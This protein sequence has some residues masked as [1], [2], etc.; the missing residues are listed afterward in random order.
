M[1]HG[2]YGILN[3]FITNA[4]LGKPI[5]VYGDG[6]QT[7]D[8]VFVNDVVDGFIRSAITPATDGEIYFIGSGVE[9]LF[10]DMVKEVIKAVGKGEYKHI[11][12]PPERESI[13][14]R[15]FVVTY[16]KFN[17]ATG[18]TPKF[19]LKSGVQKTV[20]FYQDRWDEYLK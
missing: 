7:R 12:F 20:D 9:T 1:H 10:L 19:D 15:K 8:Y 6:L 5:T 16:K 4:H 11:P 14:I 3:W 18:W 17:E 2:F 13:D